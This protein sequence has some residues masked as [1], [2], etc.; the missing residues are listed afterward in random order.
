MSSNNKVYQGNSYEFTIG[1]FIGKGGNGKVVEANII[2]PQSDKDYVLKILSINKWRDIEKKKLRYKR[3]NKEIHKVLEFQND[4]PGIMKILDFYCPDEMQHD[5]EVWYLMYKAQGFQEFSVNNHID[6]KIKIEYLLQLS[7]ILWDLHERGYSHRDI[8]VDNLLVLDNQLML[9]DFGL[10]WN[11][12]DYRITADGERLGP[13]YIGPPELESRD[14]NLDDYRSSDVYLFS[15]VVWMVIKDDMI[16]FRGEYRRDNKQFYLDPTKLGITT[17]EPIHQLL[18]KATKFS[19][20]ERI[21]IHECRELLKSQ[22]LI[23]NECIPNKALKYRFKELG[24]EI[25]NNEQPD[26]RI[27]EIFDTILRIVER[28]TPISNI[29]IEGPNETVIADSIEKWIEDKSLI[30][31]SKKNLGQVHS[32]LCYPDYIKYISKTEEFELHLKKVERESI[33]SEFV[34]YK[35]SRMAKWGIINNNIFLDEPLVIRFEKREY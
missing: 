11:V 3:F 34:S 8:K 10:I 25:V 26:E 28:L 32:Y 12:D 31:K 9:S 24:M 6:I 1:K 23:I 33:H 35:E 22:L 19:M 21:N 5:N 29:Y 27:Y 18:E 2:N 13:F 30:F 14:T 16:G 15:K 17:F 7:N 4:I 20:I